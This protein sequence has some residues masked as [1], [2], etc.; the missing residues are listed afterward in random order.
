MEE[1]HVRQTER[2]TKVVQQGHDNE[3]VAEEGGQD[4]RT[5][6]WA[7]L[8]HAHDIAGNGREVAACGETHAAE[9]VKADPHAPGL[10]IIEVGDSA[11]ARGET[12]DGDIGIF[13]APLL[14]SF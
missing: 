7:E 1:E 6:G 5:G 14:H 3:G 8:L 2:M 13:L 10:I 12:H 4:G 9:Q 11:D